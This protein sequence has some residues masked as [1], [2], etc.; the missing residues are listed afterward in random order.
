MT[1]MSS[2]SNSNGRSSFW[3]MTAVAAL[4][5][6]VAFAAGNIYLLSKTD[7]LEQQVKQVKASSQEEIA[8]LEHTLAA[9]HQDSNKSIDELKQALEASGTRSTQA[10]VKASQ[11]ARRYSD[12]LSK[13]LTAQEQVQQSQLEENKALT[14]QLGEMKELT[15]NTDTRVSGIATDVTTVKTEVSQNKSELDKTIADLHSVRGDLGVQSGLVATNAKELAALRALG[16]RDYV[17][18]QLSK[19]KTPQ[20]VGDVALQLKKSDLRRNRYTIELVANDKRIEKKDRSIN[21]PVQFYMA[22]ARIPY[23]LVVNEVTNDKIIG[24][25]SVPKVRESR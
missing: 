25:L 22:K 19:T 17:E 21:E 15:S 24:Y 23:E 2:E 9:R 13:K 1:N 10:A 20:R 11:A 14:A 7:K 8:N 5:L 4:T 12:E 3:N 16:E 6:S 18:F